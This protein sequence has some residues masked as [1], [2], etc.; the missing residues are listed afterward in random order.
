MK[1]FI[2]HISEEEK[3]ASVLK[4]WI[5]STFLDQISVFVSSDPDNL[6]AGN[7]W[8]ETITSALNES[9]LLIILYSPQSKTRLWINF[10]A[11]CGWIKEIPIIPICHSKLKLQQIGE[12]I[13]S[14]QGIDIGDANFSEKFF[15]AIKKHASFK[16]CPRIDKGQ[17]M[18]EINEAINNIEI[19][20]V[21]ADIIQN[22]RAELSDDQI[23]ILKS[24]AEAED[25]HEGGVN[26][27]E[28][29]ARLNMKVTMVKYH[30]EP[31]VNKDLVYRGL[32]MGAPCNYNITEKGISH[33]VQEG[34]LQ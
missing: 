27:P 26:E 22:D 13:S 4:E 24:L 34:I 10:E 1:V 20:N 30:L 23:Q 33:L 5:E 15:D 16:K 14:F 18:K 28:L 32:V 31:L 11:G 3:L 7:K 12:P 9:K 25:R 6:P 2:S 8:L 21:P 19:K 17:F 29:A